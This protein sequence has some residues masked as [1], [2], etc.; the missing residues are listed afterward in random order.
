ME[1][2]SYK[3]PEKTI[4]PLEDLYRTDPRLALKKALARTWDVKWQDRLE[5]I[6]ELIVADS[7]GCTCDD[8]I[9]QFIDSNPA[10]AH[11]YPL[12]CCRLIPAEVARLEKRA[13]CDGLDTG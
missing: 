9:L 11:Y 2:P 3:V 10:I 4:K 1:T 6:S 12:F 8:L 13:S 7:I 5:K